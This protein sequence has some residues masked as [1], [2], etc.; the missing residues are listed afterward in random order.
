MFLNTK[1]KFFVC[2]C[3]YMCMCVYVYVCVCV[4]LLVY[5][6]IELIN[7]VSLFQSFIYIS[8][9]KVCLFLLLIAT[10]VSNLNAPLSFLQHM[11]FVGKYGEHLT[12]ESH[13]DVL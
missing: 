10:V 7:S 11:D 9:M 13:P 8:N 12:D 3:V 4:C 2:V 1:K 6:M 5:L